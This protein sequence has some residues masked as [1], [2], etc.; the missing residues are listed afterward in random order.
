MA[1][2]LPAGG[3]IKDDD[4]AQDMKD[5]DLTRVRHPMQG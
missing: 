3:Q 4:S 2:C 1:A 5:I